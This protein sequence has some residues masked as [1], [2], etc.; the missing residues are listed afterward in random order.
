MEIKFDIKTYQG[1]IDYLKL[2]RSLY[3]IEVYF[4][5]H[6]IDEEQKNHLLD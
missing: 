4:S 2:N 6:N 3:Q 1:E 5:I